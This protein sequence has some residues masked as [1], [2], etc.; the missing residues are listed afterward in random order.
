[1]AIAATAKISGTPTVCI[2][3]PRL[4]PGGTR[5]RVVSSMATTRT[6]SR[7]SHSETVLLKSGTPDG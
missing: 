2:S 5:G 3:A 6:G 7:S 4:Q 1:M